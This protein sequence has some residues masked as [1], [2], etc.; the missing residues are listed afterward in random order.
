MHEFTDN[1]YSDSG[2][3]ALCVRFDESDKYIGASFT[4]GTLRVFN[5]FT[6]KSTTTFINNFS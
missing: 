1:I 6:G 3:E 4:N 5:S 2:V